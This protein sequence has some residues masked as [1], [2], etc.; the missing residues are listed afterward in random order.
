MS[1]DNKIQQFRSAVETKRA[2]L[3]TKPKLAY[4]TNALLDVDGGRVNLNT[5]NSEEE[6]VKIACT[7]LSA[8]H[9][10]KQANKV[11]GTKVQAKFGDSAVSRWIADIKLR[12]SLLVWERKKKKL[13]A[14]DKQLQSLMSDDAKTADAIASIAAQLEE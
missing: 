7:L 3:G 9:L 2:E 14:M 12:V 13:T 8:E 1:N 6:C 11:L 4:V 10:T 5:L